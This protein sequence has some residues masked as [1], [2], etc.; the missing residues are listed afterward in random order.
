MLDVRPKNNALDL[1]I[2]KLYAA[3]KFRVIPL[4]AWND[5]SVE[6]KLRGKKPVQSNWQKSLH[7][8]AH[9]LIENLYAKGENIGV[10]LDAWH[11]IVDVDPRNGGDE[12][13]KRLSADCGVDLEAEARVKVATGGGGLHLYF[14]KPNDW[15][16]RYEL[17]EYAGIEF[18]TVGGQVVIPPSI[19]AIT[20]EP[21]QFTFDSMG[22]GDIGQAPQSLLEKLK[23]A[24]GE[25]LFDGL[26]M[27]AYTSDTKQVGYLRDRLRSE[28]PAV[29]GQGGDNRTY[30][31]CLIGHDLGIEPETFLQVL[32]EEWNN[33]C[34]PAWDVEELRLKVANAY[35]YAQAPLGSKSA[36]VAFQSEAKGWDALKNS[37]EGRNEKGEKLP[38]AETWREALVCTKGGLVK[39]DMM[40]T[41]LYL[42]FMPE[43]KGC[44]SYSL[45]TSSVTITKPLPF[46]ERYSYKY[47]RAFNALDANNI[48][49][50]L[51]LK[52]GYRVMPEAI[53]LIVERISGNQTYH[54]IRN[55]LKKLQWDGVKRL[56][57]FLP[58]YFGTEDNA[59][60]QAVGRKVLTAAVSR[61]F[62]PGCKFDYVLVL[63]GK[64]G[65]GKSTALR[66]LGGAYFSDSVTDLTAKNLVENIQGY[67]IIELSELDALNR[68]EINT[69]K[70][71]LSRQEDTVRLSYRRDS[72]VYQRQ[73][74]FIG[75][76]NNTEY[77]KDE[78]GNR[79]FWP[80]KCGHISHEAIAAD[81]EQLFAEAV[82]RWRAKEPLYLEKELE[83]VAQAEQVN[84]QQVDEWVSSV[85]DWVEQ[86]EITEC[87]TTEV[88]ER[89]FLKPASTID[90]R[91]QYRLASVLRYLGF[92][93]VNKRVGGKVVKIFKKGD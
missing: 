72:Q 49:H 87:R 71:T 92:E 19:H 34:S 30:Q 63:E 42:T 50:Y 14:Y 36:G 57:K 40:N 39:T 67:W 3:V 15:A 60:T 10:A 64:Q 38:D 75:T 59:Y 47:P 53:S 79:R 8:P 18:K 9:S 22:L 48:G 25:G 78:T 33:R 12:S 16:T 1:S 55:Y 83:A 45:F 80:V 91:V 13:L 69:L 68:A 58:R 43:F 44:F 20:Q 5:E 81:R 29:Q 37:I 85:G 17:K 89:C 11:L 93:R 73:S 90:S 54:P 6:L 86:N 41:T 24:N 52:E 46:D 88:W 74:I 82:E 32:L 7:R 31:V 84:R 77:L 62:D 28:E 51:L 65:I 4:H 27:T 66:V 21:Y 23:K 61:V 35:R 26:G 2:A 76:T 56:D 70:A